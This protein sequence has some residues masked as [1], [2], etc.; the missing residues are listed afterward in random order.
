MTNSQ[1]MTLDQLVVQKIKNE[2][3]FALV[4]DEDFLAKLTKRAIDEALFSKGHAITL[5]GKAPL[6]P[7]VDLAKEHIR[8]VLDDKVQIWVKEF[9][10][11][12]DIDNLI[13]QVILAAFADTIFEATKNGLTGYFYNLSSQNQPLLSNLIKHILD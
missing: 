13:R 1:N 4:G 7:V 9:M 2:S 3:L 5:D 11:R 12:P 10:D 8:R 6:P